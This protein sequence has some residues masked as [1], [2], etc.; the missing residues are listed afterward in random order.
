[1]IGK[2]KFTLIR[3]AMKSALLQTFSRRNKRARVIK[4][5]CLSRELNARLTK[6]IGAANR[7][8]L[9]ASSRKQESPIEL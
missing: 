3:G 8:L 2:M 1:M 5:S 7:F 4:I 6:F 9:F